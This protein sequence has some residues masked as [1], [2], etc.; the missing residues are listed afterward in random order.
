ML[1]RAAASV[2]RMGW[3]RHCPRFSSS[4]LH[5]PPLGCTSAGRRRFAQAAA[6]GGGASSAAGDAAGAASGGASGRGSGG[7]LQW[8]KEFVNS[9]RGQMV[10]GNFSYCLQFAGFIC[11]DIL[12]MRSFL[13]GGSMSFVVY[14]LVQPKRLYIPAVWES[15]FASIHCVKIYQLLSGDTIVLSPEEMR[16]YALLF[17]NAEL[18]PKAFQRVVSLGQWRTYDPGAVLTKEGEPVSHVRVLSKGT[19]VVHAKRRELRS[20]GKGQFVGEQAVLRSHLQGT[21]AN[22]AVATRECETEVICYEWPMEELLKFMEADSAGGVLMKRFFVDVLDKLH[23][24]RTTK[25]TDELNPPAK[26]P[27]ASPQGQPPQ[28]AA[29]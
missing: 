15:T 29:S 2:A 19:V 14:A 24:V 28:G 17:E 1:L 23:G 3:Q 26:A 8:L 9:D 20:L 25:S 27:D 16:L 7:L 18:D 5:R 13:I 11:T 22:V 12:P 10:L 6:N 4:P 21:E